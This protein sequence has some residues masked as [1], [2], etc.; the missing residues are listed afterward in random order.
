MPEPLSVEDLLDLWDR[1]REEGNTL[2][3]E[4]FVARLAGQLPPE[5]LAELRQAIRDLA[6]M[7]R[8]LGTE[9][10]DSTPG[11]EGGVPDGPS[12]AG[13]IVTVQAQFR[14]DRLHA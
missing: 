9:E 4:E 14:V 11:S 8:V 6:D 7:D 13:Q 5:Q 2:S 10:R 3:P 1:Q 12:R